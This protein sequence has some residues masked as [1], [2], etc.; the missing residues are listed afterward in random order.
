MFHLA[1]HAICGNVLAFFW[2]VYSR[3]DNYFRNSFVFRCICEK[4]VFKYVVVLLGPLLLPLSMAFSPM[5][6]A[7]SVGVV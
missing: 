1:E 6:V 4:H 3:S 2:S 7:C 5:W